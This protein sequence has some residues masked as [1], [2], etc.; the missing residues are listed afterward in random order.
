MTRKMGDDMAIAALANAEW[1]AQQ[2]MPQRA[3]DELARLVRRCQ[4]ERRIQRGL[5]RLHGRRCAELLV[6][7][8]YGV[9]NHPTAI[10]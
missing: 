9:E 6:A 2:R 3:S 8:A 5:A 7:P 4:I 10:R 1:G